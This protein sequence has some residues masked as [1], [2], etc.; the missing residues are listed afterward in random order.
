MFKVEF[1]TGNAAFEDDFMFE[2]E[3]IFEDIV[4]AV[5][6][7]MEDGP[8]RDSNGNTVGKWSKKAEVPA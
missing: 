4:E 2:I 7:G 1:E 3:S 6:N 8:I 5:S